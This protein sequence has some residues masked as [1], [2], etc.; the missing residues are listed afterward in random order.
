MTS[1]DGKLVVT[2]NGEIYSYRQ[3]RSRLEAEGC[4]PA[5]SVCHQG[6]D[7]GQLPSRHVCLQYLG[8]TRAGFAADHRGACPGGMKDRDPASLGRKQF[9][10]QWVTSVTLCR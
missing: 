7:D 5:A 6:H 10:A 1:D 8:R 4:G 3:L 9:E 2:F